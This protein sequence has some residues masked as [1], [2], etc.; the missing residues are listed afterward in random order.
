M[1]TLYAL[2]GDDFRLIFAPIESDDTFTSFTIL[3][4]V[5]FMLELILAS[6]GQEGYF[7]SYFFWLDLIS[8]VSMITDIQP[9]MTAIL[10][11]G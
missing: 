5:L 6:I 9:I 2:F 3:S 8:S 10:T 1:V 4:L 11:I 7:N